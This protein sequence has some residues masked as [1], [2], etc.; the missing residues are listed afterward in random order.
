M[1]LSAPALPVSLLKPIAAPTAE[2]VVSLDD[3]GKR[4]RIEKTSKDYE[5][6]F[7]S[8]MLGQMMS[9]VKA[10]TFGGGEGEDAFKSFLTDAMAKSM[11]R[12]GGI[13]LSHSLA[14]E[15]MKMQGLSPTPAANQTPTTA[16]TKAAA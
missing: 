2:A 12:H 5:S 9:G 16:N 11:V 4:T 15:M 10:S 3:A 14:G 6:A 1:D 13:G 7:L 8:I